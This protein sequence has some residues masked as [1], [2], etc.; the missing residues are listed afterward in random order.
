MN[1]LYKKLVRW[2]A[3]VATVSSGE[4]TLE[5]VGTEF[6]DFGEPEWRTHQESAVLAN[7]ADAVR[8]LPGTRRDLDEVQVAPG[9]TVDRTGSKVGCGSSHRRGQASSQ[10]QRQA[11]PV[12]ITHPA[13]ADLALFSPGEMLSP[14]GMWQ[15]RGNSHINMQLSK[16]P[17]AG[18]AQLPSFRECLRVVIIIIS[19]L[20]KIFF[21]SCHRLG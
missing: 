11:Q 4:W 3:A 5:L 1:G 9:N 12:V 15:P 7:E 18:N 19:I 2:A 20:Q 17:S 8:A 13:R 16:S 21:C 10:P 6:L 14:E